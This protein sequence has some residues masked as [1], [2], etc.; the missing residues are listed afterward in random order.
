MSTCDYIHT[1]LDY[2]YALYRR[3]WESINELSEE[4]FVQELDY[5]HGS[6]RNQIVHVA[7]TDQRWLRGLK[8]IPGARQFTLNP[9]DYPDQGSVR[10]LWDETS[11]QVLGYANALDEAGMLRQP[12]GMFGPV[13]QVLA[14]L[15]NHGTDHR[16]Q[17]LRSLHDLGATTFDQDLILYLWM[18]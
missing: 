8:E 13:W 12:Q 3:L 9:T 1:M 16:A 11:R 14:H 2:N 18:G 7:N 15:A 5:S 4:Q 6:V 10:S 17:I